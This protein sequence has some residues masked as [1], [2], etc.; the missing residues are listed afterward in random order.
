MD[1]E[2][3]LIEPMADKNDE[4]VTIYSYDVETETVIST[5]SDVMNRAEAYQNY[6]VVG[7]MIN[8]K[9]DLFGDDCNEKED[10]SEIFNGDDYYED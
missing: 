10:Y 6:K 3:V 2:T 8:G 5:Y 4:L 9:I 7:E 1:K